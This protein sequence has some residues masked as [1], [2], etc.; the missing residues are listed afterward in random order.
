MLP[1]TTI[2]PTQAERIYNK[3]EDKRIETLTAAKWYLQ[4]ERLDRNALSALGVK[5]LSND[6]AWTFSRYII[7]VCS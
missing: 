2:L 5:G 4:N 7:H 1:S 6:I 3:Q